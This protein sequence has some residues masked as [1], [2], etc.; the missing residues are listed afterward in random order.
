M[1]MDFVA[2]ANVRGTALN[3]F[4]RRR[5]EGGTVQLQQASE[6]LEEVIAGA[7]TVAKEGDSLFSRES[8]EQQ[9]GYLRLISLLVVARQERF[10]L[11][12]TR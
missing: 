7:G 12:I 3:T 2:E 4:R 1:Q 8:R 5:K 11:Q 9:D 6:E 10:A